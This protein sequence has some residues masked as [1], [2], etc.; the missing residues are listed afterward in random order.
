MR[1]KREIIYGKHQNY[2]SLVTDGQT[3]GRTDLLI[4]MGGP[5]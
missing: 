4:E 1:S 3:H 2:K 5:I